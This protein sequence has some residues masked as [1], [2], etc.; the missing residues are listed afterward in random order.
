MKLTT[1]KF[2]IQTRLIIVPFLPLLL[3][4]YTIS[5]QV[6][7][8]P[9]ERL[10]DTVESVYGLNDLLIQ[11]K[12][13]AFPDKRIKGNPYFQGKS[14]IDANL[15]IDGHCFEQKPIMYDVV[16]QSLI[17]KAKL[18]LNKYRIIQLNTSMIDSFKIENRLFVQCAHLLENK[19]ES[20]YLEQI[21]ENRVTFARRYD[22]KFIGTYNA[23]TP[24]GKYSE[25]KEKRYIISNGKANEVNSRRA[26]VRY[27]PGKVRKS[28][29][30]YMRNKNIKYSST[31]PKRLKALANFCF[32]KLKN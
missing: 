18:K 13:Y 19:H 29:R 9:L 14:W 25:L 23:F 21:C 26:F 7:E 16:K 20:C 5:A 6:N 30:L 17:L 27:F 12:P 31:T 3:M 1:F 10:I 22:K 8:P 28:I 2:L 32:Q 11:G 15:Y 24:E 4:P